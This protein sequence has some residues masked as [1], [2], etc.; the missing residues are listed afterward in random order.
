[1][2]G[3]G[4]TAHAVPMAQT[5]DSPNENKSATGDPREQVSDALVRIDTS[6]V[7]SVAMGK[8]HTPRFAVETPQI[9]QQRQ[10]GRLTVLSSPADL[11]MTSSESP[12]GAAQEPDAPSE[13]SPIPINYS[14][15]QRESQQ[16]TPAGNTRGLA[17]MVSTS[18]I[19]IGQ[20][21]VSH[22]ENDIEIVCE[23]PSGAH[24]KDRDEATGIV[25]VT[26][27]M[28]RQTSIAQIHPGSAASSSNAQR[29]LELWW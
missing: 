20:S 25:A 17:R 11:T 14:D 3:L 10:A 4:I 22:E 15:D 21:S 6:H 2:A 5:N 8:Q 13:F 28:P 9:S 29:L 7:E 27:E 1:M 19:A 24:N 12:R 23:D 16:A 26:V 18:S